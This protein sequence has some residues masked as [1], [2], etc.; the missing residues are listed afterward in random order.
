MSILTVTNLAIRRLFIAIYLI[1]LGALGLG[2]FTQY[3]LGFAPCELCLYQ[4]VPYVILSIISMAAL[5]LKRSEK[6]WII[7][8]ILSVLSSIGLSGYHTLIERGALEGSS[9]CNPDI[10]MPDNLSTEQI[11]QQ[12]YQRDVATCTKAPFKVM[13]LSMTEWNL[14]FNLILLISLLYYLRK[15]VYATS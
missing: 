6:T 3:V 14:V 10:N 1:S 11:K 12:L 7:M 2:F 8:I 13:M 15:R 9:H 5:I 4:R